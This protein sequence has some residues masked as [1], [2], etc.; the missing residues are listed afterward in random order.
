M[1][2]G[3]RSEVGRKAFHFLCLLYLGYFHWRGRSETLSVLAVWMAVIVAV[4]TLRLSRPEV[5]AFLLKTFQGI[6]R[7]HEEKRIS[8]IIWTSSGCWLTFLLF[9]AEPRLVDAGVLCLA[10]GD[11]SAALAGKTFGRRVFEFRGK[12]K[13]L[14][15]SLACFAACAA[16][17]LACGFGPGAAAAAAAAATALE[18]A[19]PP[20]DDNFWLP[21]AAAAVLSL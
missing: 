4:E 2:G 6:H 11:A 20:P 14:E 13:S 8:A 9:G 16:S 17:V 5:N 18:L 15:G 1:S 12:R 3:W 19:A 21:L 7:P 10:F